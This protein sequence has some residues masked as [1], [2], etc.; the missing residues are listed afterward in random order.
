[1]LHNLSIHK[2]LTNGLR[3]TL[4]HFAMRTINTLQDNKHLV[5]ERF[6]LFNR[7]FKH[8]CD[9]N[10]ATSALIHAFLDFLQPL[11]T[12]SFQT[13]YFPT[14]NMTVRTMVGGERE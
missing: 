3:K 12:I 8:Y 14:L 13:C 5:T 4:C 6:M 9:Y 1:M 10:K 11:F 2:S 7:R